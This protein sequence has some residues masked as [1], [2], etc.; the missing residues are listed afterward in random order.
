MIDTIVIGLG[1]AG[2]S[3]AINLRKLNRKVLLIGREHGQLTNLDVIDNHYAQTPISG[4]ALIQKG[5]NQAKHLGIEVAY[6]VVLNIEEEN[7]VF[8]LTTEDNTYQSK[9]VVLA[10]GKP[11]V[12]MDIEGYLDF[13]SRGIHLCA[14]C[15]GLFY[16]QKK[17]GIIGAGAYLE[18]ELSTLE[19]YTN[20]IIIFTNG[21][22]YHHPTY[23]VVKDPL[24]A[25]QGEKRI[26][27]IQTD[28]QS[29]PLQGAFIAINHPMATE[30]SLKLGVIM[31]D[32]NIEV[33]SNMQTNIPGLFAAGDCIGGLLQIPKAQY[34][35]FMA[36]HGINNY[37]KDLL[38]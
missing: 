5:I 29:Y 30:L 23:P 6:D 38:S 7:G 8:T 18:Q 14:T 21:K 27:H 37:L 28:K 26:T 19:N 33:D 35:G 24:K 4:G 12:Q 36:A 15:D 34:D 11:R 25:F 1:P 31:D 32:D 16:R 20:D 13:K 10:T 9:T 3:A 2:I 17:V 22:D